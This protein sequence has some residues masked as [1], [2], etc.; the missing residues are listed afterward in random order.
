MSEC[1]APLCKICGHSHWSREPHI[2]P[3]NAPAEKRS[4]RNSP[5]PSLTG[6]L[7][8]A[9]VELAGS[10]GSGKVGSANCGT[11]TPGANSQQNGVTATRGGKPTITMPKPAKRSKPKKKA[12]K[13]GKKK[14]KL[15]VSTQA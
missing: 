12:K 15:S 10:R 5:A 14:C 11:R 8:G 1:G 6:A 2:L 9:G 7:R 4:T 3:A 13:K